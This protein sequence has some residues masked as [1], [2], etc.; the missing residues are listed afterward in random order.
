MEHEVNDVYF[1]RRET[2]NHSLLRFIG[3]L[4]F[5]PSS[6][7]LPSNQRAA[8]ANFISQSLWGKT[9][10]Q[11]RVRKKFSVI[12]P[13]LIKMKYTTLAKKCLGRRLKKMWNN[14]I[15]AKKM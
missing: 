4:H 7:V 9:Q 8:D 11:P 12:R 3:Q 5:I 6:A 14:V 2:S 10:D 1:R 13:T 15:G